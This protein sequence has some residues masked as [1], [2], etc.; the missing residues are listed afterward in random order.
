MTM[1]FELSKPLQ[2]MN[3]EAGEYED[4]KTVHVS[5]KGK[6]GLKALKSLQDII[7]KTFQDTASSQVK[8]KKEEKSD[9]EVTAEDVLAMLEMTGNSERV[10]DSV[11]DKLKHF[12]TIGTL[13]LNEHLQEEME[14]E[15]LDELYKQVL[16]DFLLAKVTRMMNSMSK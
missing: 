15:D 12:A 1:E 14:N 2:V 11:M 7:F 13:T 8:E 16:R 6:K 4:H 9:K 3:K 5:F 10:F